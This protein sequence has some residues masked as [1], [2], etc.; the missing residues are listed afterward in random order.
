[1]AK[2]IILKTLSI[3]DHILK[4]GYYS[5]PLL[6]NRNVFVAYQDRYSWQWESS[7]FYI[8]LDLALIS[9]VISQP[10]LLVAP[11]PLLC[12]LVHPCLTVGLLCSG[13][14]QDLFTDPINHHMIFLYVLS[15]LARFWQS[16]LRMSS[17]IRFSQLKYA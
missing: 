9:L 11:H 10:S 1:M 2:S 4:P 15:S 8:R 17:F 13:D 5:S 7:W 16:L 14:F 12:S 3:H 6:T